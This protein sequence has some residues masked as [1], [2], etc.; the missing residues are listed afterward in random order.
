M[1]WHGLYPRV[2]IVAVEKYHHHEADPPENTPRITMQVRLA[3]SW[4]WFRLLVRQTFTAWVGHEADARGL[5]GCAEEAL[6]A[7]PRWLGRGDRVIHH[8][9]T[10]PTVAARLAAANSDDDIPVPVRIESDPMVT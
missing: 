1:K 9:S 7:R 2:H 8:Y 10:P 6:A 4:L 3:W 5:I